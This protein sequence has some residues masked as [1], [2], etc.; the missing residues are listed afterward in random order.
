MK[1]LK[2]YLFR[3]RWFLVS[4]AVLTFLTHGSILFTQRFGIDTDAI[5]NGIHNYD[6]IGRQGLIWLAKLMGLDLDWF[7]LYYAQVLTIFLLFLSPASFSWLFRLSGGQAKG[8]GAA[9]L[10][11][12]AS[13]IVSPFWV[14]QIYFLNQSA[15][16]LLA[17]VLTAVAV[18]AAE[19]ARTDLRHRWYLLICA[20]LLIQAAFSCYQVLIMIY[21]TAVA[22]VFLLYSLKRSPSCRQQFGWIG[23]HAGVFTAGFLIYMAIS[24]LF[25]MEGG[26]YLSDQIAWT[27][28]S[29]GEGLRRCFDAIA[30]SLKNTP[31]YYTGLY[32]V[33]CLL[34]LSLLLY[35]LITGRTM[36]KGSCIL[37]MLS[38]F[39]L[40][41]TPYVFIFF[42][43]GE[44]LDR[45]QL[46]M[47]LSQGCV[48]YLT[49]LLLCSMETG[50][51][52]IF[53]ALK[54]GLLLLLLLAVCKDTLSHLSFCHRFY[55]TDE[56]VF[57]YTSRLAGEVYQEIQTAQYEEEARKLPE[58]D[59]DNILFLGYPDIPYNSTC[60]GGHVIGHSA[61]TY[62]VT[63]REPARERIL[64]FMQN[65]GYPLQVHFTEEE[66]A[67]FLQE[68]QSAFADLIDSMP[69][70]PQPGY[71]R[72]ISD[73]KS[74]QVYL[75]VKLGDDWRG[76][77][78][79][80]GE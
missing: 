78:G 52:R 16:I 19:T 46:V 63:V 74:G 25:F 49:V 30:L 75:A 59:Q 80:S 65:M 76:P 18:A 71:V 57:R 33:F 55:Y 39:F 8:E 60:I 61:F 66:R 32:G 43:G 9:F 67:V 11:L 36:G 44:I 58:S 10:A 14:S 23:Y 53:P 31:P 54:K 77:F 26:H 3:M 7:N 50:Q 24:N 22:A 29:A 68:F 48:L 70:Y 38:A 45:M 2:K 47:P 37:M 1:E 35:R 56:W 21:I 41:C 6:L 12:S 51:R 15:Q 72:W 5:M 64:L 42:Y 69:S 28:V 17:C 20:L 13:C 73:E 34:F 79:G 4:A 40:C 62:D 27:K